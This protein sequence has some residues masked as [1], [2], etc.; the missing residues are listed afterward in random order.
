MHVNNKR[1]STLFL[2]LTYIN[3][4]PLVQV[5]AK[6]HVSGQVWAGVYLAMLTPALCYPLHLHHPHHLSGLRGRSRV[7]LAQMGFALS[8][9]FPRIS[10]SAKW[11][12]WGCR[13][14]PA[15]FSWG[16][17]EGR[18]RREVPPTLSWFLPQFS[19]QH[20][21]KLLVVR[22]SSHYSWVLMHALLRF[23]FL[24]IVSRIALSTVTGKEKG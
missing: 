10:E 16:L 22:I 2:L 20:C 21:S 7:P 14:G 17:W 4:N 18:G 1:Q 3:A 6:A 8:R 11:G 23:P 24:L 19:V 15:C 9:P 5:P 13:T 12:M